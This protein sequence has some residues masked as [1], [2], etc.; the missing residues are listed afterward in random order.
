MSKSS[1]PEFFS[2][3][4]DEN[5]LKNLVTSK[6]QLPQGGM[7][8]DNLI[9]DLAT[10][11]T[12]LRSIIYSIKTVGNVS[13]TVVWKEMRIQSMMQLFLNYTFKAWYG[14]L[15]TIVATAANG[16][17]NE[18]T[19]EFRETNPNGEE[20]VWRGCSDVKC[21]RPDSFNICDAVA[22]VEMKVPFAFSDP[23]L[24]RSKALQPKQQLL[25]Q[26][27]GLLRASNR[28]H[29][30][31][32]LT[33]IFAI[34]VMYH[35]QGKAYLSRR[36]TDAKASCL[37]LLLMCCD[38]SSDEW[39]SLLQAGMG[40]VDLDDDLETLSE[41]TH[42]LDLSDA[43]SS[44]IPNSQANNQAAGPNTRSRAAGNRGDGHQKTTKVKVAY[45]TIGCEEEEAHERRL[46]DI[47]NV[48][49][50]EARCLGIRYLDFDE[51]Q[52]HNNDTT[53]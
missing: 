42:G 38:I 22:T 43:S 5:T 14:N 32:Y 2:F 4:F 52:H 17:N 41:Q 6:F 26:A 29:N 31:S 49:R 40:T 30:L 13:T 12:H 34:S 51:L 45:G 35:I 10:K 11:L 3:D 28:T 9:E 53:L 48:R 25:G 27:I 36:V 33:D 23:K 46:T 8:F 1:R 39:N 37:R 7:T 19:I 21:C 20:V 47:T 44:C 24:F 50:W 18:N 16:K 15:T